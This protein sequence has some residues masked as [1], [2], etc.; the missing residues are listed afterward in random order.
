[1]KRILAMAAFLAVLAGALL[2]PEVAKAAAADD[3]IKEMIEL[4]GKKQEKASAKIQKTLDQ[5]KE[6]DAELGEVWQQIMDY[7]SYANT[8]MEVLLNTVPENLP[9]DDSVCIIVLGLKLNDDGT[10]Q[11]ELI[12]R[13]ETGLA[14]AEAYP[15][16]YIAVTGGGTAENNPNATEGQLMGEWLLAQGMDASRVIVEDRAP[17]TV[18]NA[19]N[20]YSILKEKYPHVDS[21]VMI[22]SDY[23]VPRGCLLFQSK[24]ILDAYANGEEPLKIIASVGFE[25]G[26]QSYETFALQARGLA[27]VAGSSAHVENPSSTSP[28]VY[29]GI[30]CIFA[31]AAAIGVLLGKKMKRR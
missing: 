6:E 8:E 27:T 9:T 12:G 19:E 1:M 13:L 18:G 5:L 25:T 24:F 20:T 28:W 22:S 31:A 23:H 16:S 17:D 2:A 21:I 11:E 4:Y 15:N 3:Y 10:M 29:V 26:R 14:I 7:W 30:G